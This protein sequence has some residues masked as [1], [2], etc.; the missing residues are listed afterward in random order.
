MDMCHCVQPLLFLRLVFVG[1]L[2]LLE[3]GDTLY[4]RLFIYFVDLDTFSNALKQGQSQLAPKVLPELLQTGKNA[5]GAPPTHQAH[6]TP[7]AIQPKS[8]QT[9]Q[10]PQPT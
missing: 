9:T 10:R 4:H 7:Y 5:P 2:V 8:C 3:E 6:F 1:R